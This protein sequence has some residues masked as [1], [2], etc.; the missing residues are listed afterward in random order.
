MSAQPTRAAQKRRIGDH[1]DEIEFRNDADRLSSSAG[2]HD[3]LDFP[4][5]EQRPTEPP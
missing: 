3:P 2:S 1:D 4:S 5:I